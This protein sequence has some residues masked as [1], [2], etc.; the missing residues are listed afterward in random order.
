MLGACVAASSA[1]ILNASV[2]QIALPVIQRQL[3][4]DLTDMQWVVEAYLLFLTALTLAGGALGD[5]YGLQRTFRFGIV[6]FAVATLLCGFSQTAAQL[7]AA[8]ALQG[9]GAAIMMPGSLALLSSAYP[10]DQRGR[11]VGIWATATAAAV[12]MGPLLGGWAVQYLGWRWIFFVNPPLALLALL[13]LAAARRKDPAVAR[14]ATIDWPGAL[15]A[16]TGLGGVTVALLEYPRHGAAAPLVWGGFVIGLAMLAAFIVLERRATSP[17]LPLSAFRNRTF[18]GINGMTVLFYAALQGAMFYL[19]FNLLQVQG[20]TPVQAGAT[21]LPF[22][23]MVAAL[24]RWSG[25]LVD[26]FGPR[27][28]LF[29]GALLAAAGFA[30]LGLPGQA[31]PLITGYL[32]GVTVL[33]AGF[34]IAI[35]PITTVALAAVGPERVGLASAVNNAAARFG[36]LMAI[37]V[38]GIVLSLAFQDALTAGLSEQT[39]NA[40]ARE[41]AGF[42][43]LEPPRNLPPELWQRYSDAADAAFIH[44]FRLLMAICASLALAAALIA[45]R[46]TRKS[47][48]MAIGVR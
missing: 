45:W 36:G 29:A 31:A 8:R 13:M 1:G 12:S 34:G 41:S 28:P 47:N 9:L 2:V 33:G 17:M 44:G 27:A 40:G 23:V 48:V 39:I 11:A 25:G 16:T 26:R 35:T 37:A 30:L 20:Y 18:T 4:A 42:V 3:D 15:A 10:L 5:R 19:P 43:V 32:P 6:I 21:L 14:T 38:L 46:I 7:I 22:A 24:S